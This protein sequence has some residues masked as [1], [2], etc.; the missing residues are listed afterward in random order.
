MLSGMTAA[1]TI[2]VGSAA[3][4]GDGLGSAEGFCVLVGVGAGVLIGTELLVASISGL[5]AAAG[6]SA[7][8]NFTGSSVCKVVGC[9]TLEISTVAGG[10]SSSSLGR[11]PISIVSA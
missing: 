6:G 7:V 1:M 9:L 3:A 5:V 8:D 2:S 4:G 11:A 10:S